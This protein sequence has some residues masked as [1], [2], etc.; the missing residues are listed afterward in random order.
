VELGAP[1]GAVLLALLALVVGGAWKLLR[2]RSDRA[3]TAA[4][5]AG[6]AALAVH[7]IVEFSLQLAGVAVPAAVA[8]GTLLAPW[9]K[10]STDRP[11]G[12]RRATGLWT[13]LLAATVLGATL[14]GAGTLVAARHASPALDEPPRGVVLPSTLR[15]WGRARVSEL[16]DRAVRDA[17]EPRRAGPKPELAER[18]GP[19]LLALQRAARLAPLRPE[20]QLALWTATQA[21]VAA[22][23]R[24]NELA[25]RVAPLLGHYLRRAEALAPSDRERRLVLARYWL[26]MGRRDE[27]RR[28][29]RELLEMAPERAADAYEVLGGEALDLNDLLAATP[30]EPDAAIRLS[31]YLWQR[32]D[33]VGAQLVLERALSRA[34]DSWSLRERLALRLVH[35][36]REARALEVLAHRPQPEDPDVQLRIER[37]RARAFAAMGELNRLQ[38][39]LDR[40]AALGASDA[41]LALV[42]GRAAARQGEHEEA[43]EALRE[44]LAARRPSLRERQRLQAL[45]ILGRLLREQGDYPGAL[46]RYREARRIDPDHPAVVRFFD[47]LADRRR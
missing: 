39:A 12:V 25:P 32:R 30:N 45:L 23:P 16:L 13:I 27:A 26:T 18:L 24:R 20:P 36:D 28:V 8:V 37:L 43:M 42:R 29:V 10:R 21:F 7:E 4:L 46:E 22:H 19:P 14:T 3:I 6:L 2:R 41:E 1:G 47:E 40:L 17:D 15:S 11:R 9:T 33:R 35:R 31:N 5:T 38:R 34:P 44:A